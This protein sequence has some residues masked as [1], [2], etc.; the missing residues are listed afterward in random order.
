MR[1]SVR[2]LRRQY[3]FRRDP[4]LQK[5]RTRETL[6]LLQQLDARDPDP[7]VLNL[8]AYQISE[9]PDGADL[10]MLFALTEHPKTDVR[11]RALC[12]IG[13]SDSELA[14]TYLR[15]FLRQAEEDAQ[16]NE[17]CA[18]CAGLGK[19]GTLEDAPLLSKLAHAR[20][21]T[22][23][24]SAAFNLQRIRARHGI[25]EL[26]QYARRLRA[27]TVADRAVFSL[28]SD[29]DGRRYVIRDCRGRYTAAGKTFLDADVLLNEK[30]FDG[31][32][33]AERWEETRFSSIDGFHPEDWFILFGSQPNAFMK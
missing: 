9:I 25:I 12:A 1:Y 15:S 19:N 5:R 4:L 17:I 8:L 20:R 28:E 29:P 31:R 22:I 24:E 13:C 21:K 18:A 6:R 23:R 14:R 16:R 30:L 7:N 33:L 26:E 32:S 10:T 3:S 27:R 11:E 2:N